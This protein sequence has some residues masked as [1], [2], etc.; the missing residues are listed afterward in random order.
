LK[1]WMDR[2]PQPLREEVLAAMT[3]AR[4]R[5]GEL[6]YRAGDTGNEMYQILEGA[7]RIYTLTDD[8]RELLYDIFSAGN[9]FGEAVLLDDNPRSHMVEAIGDVTLGVLSRADFHAF[10]RRDPEFSL[11]IAW[12]LSQRARRMFELYEGVSLAA[13]SRRMAGRLCSLAKSVGHMRNGTVYFDLRLT[14]EDIGAL[15]AGSRQSVNKILK[16]WQ[17]DGVIDV[18]Y[19]SLV[20][21]K[22]TALKSLGRDVDWLA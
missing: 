6:I 11:A 8:G 21:K 13:L 14:Q 5:A 16:Q 9:V 18:A 20:I 2:L 17:L 3:T 4:F 10:W 22:L 7:V 19:G 15:V 1:T 12:V